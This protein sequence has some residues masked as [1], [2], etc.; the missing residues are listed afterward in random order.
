M[1][2][3]IRIGLVNTSYW[4]DLMLIPALQSHPNAEVAAICG[5]D[6]ERTQQIAVKFNIPGVYV[7]YR[8]M[9]READ[10][11]AMIIAA[12][13]DLHFEI[14][15]EAL[16]A[17]LHVFCEKP[18]AMNALQAREMYDTAESAGVIHMVHFTYR[19]MPFFQYVH[20]LIVEGFVGRCYHCEFRYLA[21]YGRNPEYQWRFDQKRSNGVLGDLGTHV[22]DLARWL[23]G[24]IRAVQALLGVF[25]E[26]EGVDGSRIDPA[27]DSA[28]LLIEFI[29]GA[30]G[31]IQASA[32]AHM[33][34]RGMQQQINLY[35]DTGSLEIRVPFFGAE[36]GAILRVARSSDE[37][38]QQLEV[39]H[40]YWGGVDRSDPFG[41]FSQQSVGCRLFVDA[42]MENR[43]VSPSF[44][45]GYKA[46]Q[47]VDAALESHRSGHIQVIDGL[48]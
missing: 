45:D 29:N 42:I 36:A 41:I 38:F 13:H 20:D 39:P 22:I 17:G 30:H 27:N 21:D 31:F 40:V 15:M 23:V 7:D 46:Q 35:G 12:P 11:N 10:V 32:V 2:E 19:W 44:Y 3:K 6:Q 9:I 43:L 28:L 47:V 5:R 34:D 48:D 33:A 8:R 14:T 37:Q 16:G 24:D 18:L 26:R 4:A 25:V 1:S